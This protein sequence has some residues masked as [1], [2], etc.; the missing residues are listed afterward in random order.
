MRSNHCKPPQEF[1]SRRIKARLMIFARW[2]AR[3]ASNAL[4]E[5]LRGEIVAAARRPADYRQPGDRH[6]AAGRRRPD[7]TMT[8]RIPAAVAAALRPTLSARARTGPG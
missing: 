3:R 4:I 2:R 6:A 7:E 1:A 5:Q 8:V